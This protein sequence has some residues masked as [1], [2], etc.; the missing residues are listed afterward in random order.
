MDK[1]DTRFLQSL[2]GYNARR[3]SLSI[4]SVFYDRMAR[5]RLSTVD[6]SV[7]S[8]IQYN[9]GITSRQLCH[10]LNILPPNFV[11][12]LAKLQERGLVQRSPHPDDKRAI[13]LSLTE[14]GIAL[15]LKAQKTAKDLEQE[16]ASKLSPA[17]QKTIMRLLQKLYTSDSS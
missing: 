2:L 3:A 8:V 1:V 10:T 17:E 13:S 16:A 4:V 14:P 7:L 6:F 11:G 9:S 15:M 12:L 5:Y